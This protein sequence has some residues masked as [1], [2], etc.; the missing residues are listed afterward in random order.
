MKKFP[1]EFSD[2]LSRRGLRLLHSP[3]AAGAA[4]FKGTDRYFANYTN[5]IDHEKAKHCIT[6]MD[7][8]LRPR[9]AIEQR[10]IPPDSISGMNENYEERLCKT[11]RLKTAFFRRSDAR[12]YKAAERIGLL[13]MMQSESFVAF[14]EAVTG[15]KLA[16]EWNQQVSCYEHGD[17]AGPHNDHHPEQEEMKDG[18]VDLHV[19]FT[20]RAVAHQY[21]VYEKD[22]HFS[23]VVDI[24]RPTGVSVY[25]LPF[26]HYTTPLHAKR[27]REAEARR[28]LLLG[29]FQILDHRH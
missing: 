25:E 16:R 8:Y 28:W 26:W 14:A 10:R 12:S 6:L 15:F 7:A 3:D 24:S 19:M 22:G 13:Q 5:V 1:R 20:N 27:G 21:M 11:M 9:L 4:V 18:F 17:Y 2:L 29:T 23:Q